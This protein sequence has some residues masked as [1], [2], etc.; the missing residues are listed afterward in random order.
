MLIKQS[1]S[2]ILC[3]ALVGYAALSPGATQ[4]HAN[5]PHVWSKAIGTQFDGDA[6]N[7]VVAHGEALYV[8]GTLAINRVITPYLARLRAHDGT[9]V[10]M[11]QLPSSARTRGIAVT[12]TGDVIVVGDFVGNGDV[13]VGPM[14]NQGED[15]GFVAR[16]SGVDGSP[17]WSR[18]FGAWLNDRGVAAC[19][20]AA[21]DVYVACTFR[22]SATFGELLRISRGYTDIAILKFD[23]NGTGPRWATHLGGPG[24]DSVEDIAVCGDG[25]AVTGQFEIEA[26]FG[27]GWKQSAGF[28][29]IFVAR[30]R[31]TDGASVWS[32]VYGG[33]GVDHARA[34]GA[35]S[36]GEIF[37]TGDFRDTIVVGGSTLVSAGNADIL[38]ARLAPDGT[39]AWARR[40]GQ[41]ASR[42]HD[43]AGEALSV[44]GDGT[45]V[46]AG[47]FYGTVDFGGGAFTSSYYLTG[48]ETD[49]FVA[50]YDREGRHV[51][52]DGF[53]GE[54]TGLGMGDGWQEPTS[55]A[56]DSRGNVYIAGRFEN[57]TDFGGGLVA[58]TGW[59]FGTA[60]N[61]G[62]VARYTFPS[63]TMARVDWLL[64]PQG[65]ADTLL[66]MVDFDDGALGADIPSGSIVL[67]PP[68]D[69]AIEIPARVT[70]N[71]NA[72][73]A[74]G[75]RVLLALSAIHGGSNG[76]EVAF[77]IR[78]NENLVGTAFARIW[79]P[80]LDTSGGVD[81]ID[82][83][84]FARSFGACPGGNGYNVGANFVRHES[85]SC[86]DMVDFG[87]FARHF[88]HG[89]TPGVTLA[90][91]GGAGA[92]T[93]SV[94]QD[95]NNPRAV[96]LSLSGVHAQ[97]AAGVRVVLKPGVRVS[98]WTPSGEVGA[99]L[100]QEDGT[101]TL[102]VLPTDGSLNGALTLGTLT[103]EGSS[104]ATALHGIQD[105]HGE[106]VSAAGVATA[107]E[108]AA[109]QDG[110]TTPRQFVNALNACVPNPFNPSTTIAF[111]V[112][113]RGRVDLHVYDVS[114]RRVRALV[115]RE[116]P[117][118]NH[119]SLW[120][121]RDDAGRAV[122]SGVYFYRIVAG[123]FVAS[124]KMVLLK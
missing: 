13:G 24:I 9:S 67:D 69:G 46:V 45:V 76:G 89:E 50:A 102:L 40:F 91:S 47:E 6:V 55:V 79:S 87:L 106:T 18:P 115:E 77:P 54:L 93:L 3:A 37:I 8:T 74:N 58:P 73:S 36:D 44:M 25:V 90:G 117:A 71:R 124:Q 95:D 107:L 39:P 64:C 92:G 70:A 66:V 19:V 85:W 83:T 113:E 51:W 43:E 88:G 15:D 4:V 22:V 123:S 80:D 65:D 7:D 78:V 101:L 110:G 48:G 84:R 99:S 2:R 49:L 33:K 56:L 114:G 63:V 16:Y 105:A 20:D 57:P 98:N 52:S 75:H 53:G 118:G 108:L 28:S 120:D 41:S 1:R 27:H 104:G 103:L 72:T 62:F 35:G 68:A 34:I 100:Q 97:A 42:A 5:P 30:L 96:V 121:G 60:P 59:P 61:E 32:A 86:V 12:P 111:S 81:V 94:L 112:S 122:A 17:V 38:L 29:D 14:A 21:G 26:N 82:L 10:W 31:G 119:T 11:R 109:P 116:V 23:G